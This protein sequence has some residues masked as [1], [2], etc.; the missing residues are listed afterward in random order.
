MDSRLNTLTN[1]DKTSALVAINKLALCLPVAGDD[2]REAL[3][4]SVGELLY[5]HNLAQ[6]KELDLLE[7]PMPLI[8]TGCDPLGVKQPSQ[9][10]VNNRRQA[11]VAVWKHL[12]G[13]GRPDREQA[14]EL[15]AEP[16]KCV[17]A[18]KALYTSEGSQVRRVD[19]RGAEHGPE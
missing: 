18:L 7:Q 15:I 5:H 19:Q 9:S 16:D 4:H 13:E 1:T 11:L 2:V 6:A 14:E 8:K 17:A 10:V 3:L 12:G